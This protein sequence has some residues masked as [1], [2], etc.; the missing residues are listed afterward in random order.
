M[1]RAGAWRWAA[2]PSLLG[3]AIAL[4]AVDAIAATPA[5]QL[6]EA[7]LQ[8]AAD[9]TAHP[10][11]TT[12][13]RL[14]VQYGIALVLPLDLDDNPTQAQFADLPRPPGVSDR[15]WQAL[16]A[17][18]IDPD[19]I[20]DETRELRFTLVDLDGDGHL[21][22]VR[23]QYI[24]GTGLF[25]RIS[26]QRQDPRDGFAPLLADPL[27]D[28][29]PMAST[30][31][32]VDYSINGRGGDQALDLLRIDGRVVA[33]YRD[34]VHAMDTLSVR[35][36]F[37]ETQPVQYLQIRYALAHTAQATQVPGEPPTH[38]DASLLAAVN[39][40]LRAHA[41]HGTPDPDAGACPQ[42]GNDNQW[43]W[44]GPGHYTF[45]Y[46]GSVPVQYRNQC[47]SA[48]VV[49]VLN[50]YRVDPDACCALWLFDETGEQV[51]DLALSTRRRILA[52]D[53]HTSPPA[54]P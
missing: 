40:Q 52:I 33:V 48:T 37:A 42:P 6:R 7:I 35:E 46:A 51:G 45:E 3:V 4:L 47:L 14:R 34:S 18:R 54:D 49:H 44:H 21:D 39:R 32:Q 38:V 28:P 8:A 25:S 50:S 16:T 20:Q 41:W 26:L 22:L 2:G 11:Q 5:M 36:P 19:T 23:D 43:P 17:L 10:L 13:E 12:I 9:G 27:D 1:M 15:D 29:D 53:L 24:G 31:G 30:P